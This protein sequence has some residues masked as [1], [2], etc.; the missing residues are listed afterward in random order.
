[1]DDE[2][3][4]LGT[5]QRSELFSN[6]A[7]CVEDALAWLRSDWLPAGSSL[8]TVQAGVRSDAVIELARIKEKLRRAEWD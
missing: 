6:A 7:D 5:P 8:S 3:G 2:H 4:A 1:M